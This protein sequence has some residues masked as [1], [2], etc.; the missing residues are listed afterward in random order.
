MQHH[1]GQG[2]RLGACIVR[3]W[4]GRHR[5]AATD[6]GI[7][8]AALPSSSRCWLSVGKRSRRHPRPQGR[9]NCP[10]RPASAGIC[11]AGIAEK[12]NY[13]S[14][15]PMPA[16]ET[17]LWKV[18]TSESRGGRRAEARAHVGLGQ[19]AT[20]TLP[21]PRG[22][23]ARCSR[24][25]GFPGVTVTAFALPHPRACALGRTTPSL[26]VRACVLKKASS[27]QSSA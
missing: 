7:A 22:L 8:C 16:L 15:G 1:A 12:R 4:T 20:H 23:C 26:Q 11:G 18:M 14:T 2:P 9:G 6:A 17:D 10:S 19:R 21:Q 25:D 13:G 24:P 3:G 27:P 5:A